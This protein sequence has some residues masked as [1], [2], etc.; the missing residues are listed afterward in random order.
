MTSR[1]MSAVSHKNSKAELALRRALHAAGMRY[2]LHAKDVLGKPDIVNRTRML[3]VFV[4]GDLWHGNPEEV[5]RRG[6]SSLAEL[7]PTRTD[8]WVAKIE[9][10]MARDRHVTS[11]LQA[12][13]WKVVRLWEHDILRNPD[14]CAA[15]VIDAAHGSA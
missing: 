4:D 9:R 12:D 5:R 14:G 8:W 1:M 2:R 11:Q 13:G 7:F 3:A 6:R 15:I 10:N